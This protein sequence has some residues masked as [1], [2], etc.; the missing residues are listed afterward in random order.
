MR[1]SKEKTVSRI[2][3]SVSMR[4]IWLDEPERDERLAIILLRVMNNDKVADNN[5]RHRCNQLEKNRE[6]TI[7][8]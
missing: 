7:A 8:L 2:S 5:G 4:G 1:C 6:T 3:L